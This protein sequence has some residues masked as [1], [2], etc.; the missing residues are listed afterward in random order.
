M[1]TKRNK[2]GSKRNTT[3]PPKRNA[4]Y[5]PKKHTVGKNIGVGKKH[6]TQRNI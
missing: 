6:I 4:T 1:Y 3:Y 2:D 5:P